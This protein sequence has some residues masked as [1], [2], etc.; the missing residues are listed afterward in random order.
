VQVETAIKNRLVENRLYSERMPRKLTKP[1]P[2]QGARLA[3]LRRDAGLSQIELARLVGEPQQNIALWE[4]S[5]RPP[6]SDVIPKLA[7]ALGVRIEDLFAE[8]V[9]PPRRNG[10]VGKVRNLFEEVA[11]LPRGQQDKIVEFLA[12]VI[13]KYKRERKAG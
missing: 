10:P 9:T 5:D 8:T 6:R 11:N 12:P 13:E 1:R 7:R 3:A 2:T 4:Q